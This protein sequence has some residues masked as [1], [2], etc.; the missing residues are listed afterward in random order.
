MDTP[1]STPYSIESM[2]TGRPALGGVVPGTLAASASL[3]PEVTNG[4]EL[5]TDFAFRR[6]GLGV[7]LTYYHEKTSDLILPV[8]NSTGGLAVT[9]IG[10][11]TNQGVDAR[12]TAQLGDGAEGLGWNIAANASKNSN[13]VDAAL[14]GANVGRAW[15]VALGSSASRRGLDSLS[16]FFAGSGCS[17]TRADRSCSGTDCPSAILRQ[18]RSS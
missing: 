3:S 12:L 5:G 7:G 9:N 2:Y 16:A 11:I 8:A 18:V 17:A 13:Q 15:P 10:A 6:F 1:E 14:R 4:F